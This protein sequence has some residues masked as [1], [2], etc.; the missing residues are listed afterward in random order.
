MTISRRTAIQSGIATLAGLACLPGVIPRAAAQATQ[1]DKLELRDGTV[2]SIVPIAHASLALTTA[3]LVIVIDPVGDTAAFADLPPA[4]LIL[5][6]HEH[7]DHFNLDTLTALAADAAQIVA[8]SA[9]YE[10]L[11]EALRSRAIRL[12]NGE[13]A[14]LA[15]VSI[16]A[17]PAYNITTDRLQYH[18]K[19]RDNGYILSLGG[20]RIYVAGDTEDTPELRATESIDV[21]FL[22][23]N[24]PFT[25]SVEQAA[26][27]VAAFAPKVVYPYHSRGSDVNAFKAL[28]DASGVASEVR[29]AKWY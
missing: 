17:V 27:A 25:M 9:V 11:P 3:D 28:V 20:S 15:G 12:A 4:N 16:N 18:P 2:L 29:L 23:M 7:Q 19:G 5:L 26:D 1:G 6:T 21:V 14:D 8:N 24:L 10:Q 22:P 13:A